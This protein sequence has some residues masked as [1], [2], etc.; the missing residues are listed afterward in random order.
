[1][2]FTHIKTTWGL[3]DIAVGWIWKHF[4]IFY[5]PNNQNHTCKYMTPI[6]ALT[7]IFVKY[8][9]HILKFQKG[10]KDLKKS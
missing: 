7:S 4:F 5:L 2:P 6:I 10:K 8:G 9:K 1:M 3:R